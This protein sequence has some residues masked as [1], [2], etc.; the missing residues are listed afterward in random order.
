MAENDKEKEL[1]LHQKL[2]KVLEILKNMTEESQKLR[3][4]MEKRLERLG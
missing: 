2:D 4:L 1:N 3:E